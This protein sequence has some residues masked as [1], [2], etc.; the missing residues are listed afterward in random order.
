[1]ERCVV[2]WVLLV[3]MLIGGPARAQGLGDPPADPPDPTEPTPRGFFSGRYEPADRPRWDVQ[4]EPVIW[5]VSPGGDVALGG[6]PI[7]PTLELNIDSPS[8]GGGGEVHLRA[9]PYRISLLGFAMS[10]R[11]G[12]TAVR[13]VTYNDLAISPGDRL[14]TDFDFA[15]AEVRLGWRV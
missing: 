10:Q 13:S 9:D 8:I 3:V 12:A 6:G 11:G 4:V 1:M 14:K 15:V 7:T 5:Y 2:R